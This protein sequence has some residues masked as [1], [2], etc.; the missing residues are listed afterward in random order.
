MN[1]ILY[2][3]KTN[4]NFRGRKVYLGEDA[5]PY[6][7]DSIII[8]AD[9]LGGRG[10]F[11]HTKF[12][13]E[14]FNKDIFYDL[15]F[16]PVFSEEVSDEFK[17]FVVNSFNEIF[18]TKDYYFEFSAT[19][20]YSGYYASRLATA[21]TVYELKYNEYFNK[22][23]VFDRI[24]NASDEEREAIAQEY[25]DKLAELLLDKLSQIAENIGFHVEV[26]VTGAY[27][28]PTT[29][30]VALT[31]E[32]EGKVET[33]YLWA[34]D[35]RAYF[36]DKDGLAQITED[37]EK[38]E[39]MTNLISL[40][41]P[42]RVEAR[43]LTF[44]KPCMLINA[45]DGCYKCTA[46]DSPFDLEYIFLKSIDDTPSFEKSSEFLTEHFSVLGTHDDSN[47]MSL[48]SFGYDSYED[49]QCAVRERLKFIDDTVLSR[50]PDILNIDYVDEL[51]R[52]ERLINQNAV[53]QKDKLIEAESIVDFVRAHMLENDYYPMRRE[54][55]TLLE[56]KKEHV[57][58]KGEILAEM[59]AW[60]HNNWI[61]PLQLKKY[62]SSADDFMKSGV[63]GM[64][65]KDPY[66][67]YASYSSKLKELDMAH[68][69]M[70]N[71]A[72]D[73]FRITADHIEESL[74]GLMD[75]K[76]TSD[77]NEVRFN[78]DKSSLLA[79]IDLIRAIR[80]RE[81]SVIRKYRSTEKDLLDLQQSYIENDGEAI[82]ELLSGLV[83]KAIDLRMVGINDEDLEELDDLLDAYGFL[84]EE[85]EATDKEIAGL[86]DKYLNSYWSE[87]S[88]I[89]VALIWNEHRDLIPDELV[90]FISEGIVELTDKQAELKR[91]CEIRE[92][93]YAEY[94][95]AYRRYYRESKI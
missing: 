62:S 10:G 52:V 44:D 93:I 41:L 57:V 47:T 38:H 5:Y 94:D 53:S 12:N 88:S 50:L 48:I 73:R 80:K 92:E 22:E 17:E 1:S 35:S 29:L 20:K 70:V 49:I 61:G 71:D 89:L 28:L 33:L 82:E 87:K 75:I 11:P 77:F 51:E 46:F 18:E 42:F 23:V 78:A 14:I 81:T 19:K 64:S 91:C 95:V 25:G 84:F 79:I 7:D 21:I 74:E 37:H 67:A 8:V 43:Y 39:T 2:F 60:I 54:R 59:R 3:Q 34:G 55:N 9:G 90:A 40:T 4:D 72:I 32:H 24:R 15:V 86:P 31:N 65:K 63:F 56:R 30:T 27:L 68:T 45:T 76:D 58:K 83:S 6:A 13:I 36:W 85:V 69:Q 26:K 66:E 16:A